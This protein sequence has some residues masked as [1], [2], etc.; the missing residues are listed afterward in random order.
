MFLKLW[1]LMVTGLV[2]MLTRMM[3]MMEFPIF[4]NKRMVLI[5]WMRA[6]LIQIEMVLRMFMMHFPMMPLR[7]LIPMVMAL[8][9]ILISTTT[10]MVLMIP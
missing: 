10:M 1:I 3:I 2:T 7:A 8:E 5:L 9:I 4:R 6:V